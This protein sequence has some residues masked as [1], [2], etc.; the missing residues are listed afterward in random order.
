MA[1]HLVK[2]LSSDVLG[3]DDGGEGFVA[4]SRPWALFALRAVIACESLSAN[5]AAAAFEKAHI[6]RSSLNNRA[7]YREDAL[8]ARVINSIR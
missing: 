8:I 6:V 1:S 3:V 2:A 7:S 4:R 5:G